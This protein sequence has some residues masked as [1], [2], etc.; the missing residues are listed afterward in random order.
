MSTY[1][2]Y[3]T[4]EQEKAVKEFLETLNVPFE[5]E[6]DVN[7][8]LAQYVLDGIQRGL[9]DAAAGRTITLEEFKRKHLST[10]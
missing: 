3:P 1:L 2:V 4:N 5:K 10:K 9:D 8:E 6:E 7:E